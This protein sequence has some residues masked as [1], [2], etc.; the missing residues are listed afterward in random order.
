MHHAISDGLHARKNKSLFNSE[1]RM[2]G[3]E[4]VVILFK[5]ITVR[6]DDKFPDKF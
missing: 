4:V 5:V 3:V 1:G 6:R 2:N